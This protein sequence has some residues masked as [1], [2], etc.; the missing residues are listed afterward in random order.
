MFV[1][2]S[3]FQSTAASAGIGLKSADIQIAK[4]LW[5]ESKQVWCKS[6]VCTVLGHDLVT[7]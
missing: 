2:Q 5:R 1:P 6:L 4:N 7:S 3:N